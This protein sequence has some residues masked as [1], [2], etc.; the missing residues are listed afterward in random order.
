MSAYLVLY[1]ME[2]PFTPHSPRPFPAPATVVWNN[3]NNSNSSCTSS[4]AS[5]NSNI[6]TNTDQGSGIVEDGVPE[7]KP[8]S[9]TA[10]TDNDPNR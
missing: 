5:S 9:V 4:T 8:S 6:N 7:A 3:S 2:R 1:E 10:L